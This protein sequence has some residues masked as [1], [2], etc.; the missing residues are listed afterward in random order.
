MR[1]DDFDR[2]DNIDDRRGQSDGG[3]GGGGFPLGGGGLGIG[4]LL[5]VGLLSYMTGINPAV[6]LGGYEMINGQRSSQQQSAPAPSGK[7]GKPD[8]QMG[9]F[10][11]AI[12]GS[13]ETE[14]SEIFKSMGRTYEKPR[15]VLFSQATRSGCGRAQSAMGPFYCPNDRQ[16]YLD[17]AFFRELQVRFKGCN[18]ASSCQFA[19]AYVIAHEV[20]HHVQNLT[21]I[22]E[23]AE[24]AKRSGDEVNAN[25]IQVRVELQADCFAGV[26]AYHTN[27]KYRA[28]DD[29][30]VKAALQTASAIGDDMLQRKAQ[31]YVVPDSFT[32]GS[33]AQRQRWFMAGLKSG[34]VKACNTFQAQS[35]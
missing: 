10:V 16:V 13:T 9:D 22:L 24:R 27:Q 19:N 33:S 29:N 17:T 4:G 28:I 30:D 34:D 5:I 35:L 26:W 21:G 14:W 3:G 25:R 1:Y 32:H 11:A 15:L 31:G 6:L 20:G 8:D 23:K 2:S 18:D 7:T 12:L